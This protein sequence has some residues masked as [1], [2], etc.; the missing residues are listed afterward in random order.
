MFE[1]THS[2]LVWARG[3]PDESEACIGN[4][5]Y[6]INSVNTIYDILIFFILLHGISAI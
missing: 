6:D 4:E 2:V 3:L 5:L 1:P